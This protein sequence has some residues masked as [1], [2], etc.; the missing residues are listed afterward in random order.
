MPLWVRVARWWPKSEGT[1]G[2][3]GTSIILSRCY[4]PI[5]SAS[6]RMF[7]FPSPNFI[8]S[9]AN[10]I[11]VL[12]PFFCPCMSI[13]FAFIVNC[14]AQ[15]GFIKYLATFYCSVHPHSCPN[16]EV[17]S[18]FRGVS[19]VPFPKLMKL[20][21][22]RF[23]TTLNVKCKCRSCFFFYLSRSTFKVK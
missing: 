2:L 8:P 14:K 11:T 6:S 20:S 23:S 18:L 4:S 17:G 9:N 15:V 21:G 3:F 7:F 13:M 16:Q 12:Y 1:S 19:T 10:A 22:I 5:T